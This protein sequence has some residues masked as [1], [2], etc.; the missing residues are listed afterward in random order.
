MISNPRIVQADSLDD[1]MRE[2]A[3][4]GACGAG[5]RA[6]ADKARYLL[7]RLDHV[8]PIAA[9]IMKQEMLSKGGEA[10][11]SKGAVDLSVKYSSVLLMGTVKQ[12]KMLISK[13]KLQQFKL[14][15]IAKEIE[16]LLSHVEKKRAG[17]S[18]RL[19]FEWGKRTYIMGILNVTPDSFSDGGLYNDPEAAAKRAVEM[20]EEGA[21]IID[22]GA[23]STRPGFRKISKEEEADRLF[24]VLEKVLQNVSIPVSVDTTTVEIAREAISMGASWINDVSG[25]DLKPEMTSLA[26]E[27]GVPIILMHNRKEAVYQD[28]LGEVIFDIRKSVEKALQS[29]VEETQIIIDPGIGFG[30][31]AEHNLIILKNLRQ[32][33]TL[34]F[35]VLVGTSRK[36]FIGKV[37]DT[38]PYDRL[39]GTAATVAACIDRGADIIRVHDVVQMRRVAQMMDRILRAG[40]DSNE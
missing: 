23:E 8:S 28:L 1:A 19:P 11:V 40:D 21:D 30:K 4:V 9:N 31:T 2:I 6:M 16:D 34:G 39:E 18:D 15:A 12:Y 26:A 35:P 3:A 27:S 22:I 20:E 33:T 7:I 37:L 32:I 13:L 24:P 17:E 36:S 14:P 25:P 10:A 38:T 29:G 5:V